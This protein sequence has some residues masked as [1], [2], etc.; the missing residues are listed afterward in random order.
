MVFSA[1]NWIY[2]GSVKPLKTEKLNN[3]EFF[4]EIC[5]YICAHLHTVLCRSEGGSTFIN[6][7]GWS[8]MGVG[9]IN[10]LVNISNM[11]YES[12]QG[13]YETYWQKKH[14]KAI[15]DKKRE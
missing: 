8:S 7:I 2:L 6:R 13:T 1:I 14:K 9:A 15:E 12:I 4:N 5:I 3:F 10:I 11:L